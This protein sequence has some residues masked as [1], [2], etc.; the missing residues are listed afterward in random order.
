MSNRAIKDPYEQMDAI[1]MYQDGDAN[2]T[3]TGQQFGVSRQSIRRLCHFFDN[4]PTLYKNLSYAA[5]CLISPN[6]SRHLI[7][8]GEL[9]SVFIESKMNTLIATGIASRS[10]ESDAYRNL[11][12][13]LMNFIGEKSFPTAEAVVEQAENWWA[14][15]SERFYD[16]TGQDDPDEYFGELDS[17]DD[18]DDMDYV[19]EIDDVKYSAIYTQSSISV[20]KVE[21][22]NSV[23]PETRTISS[24]N[25]Q[26]RKA[27]RLIKNADD[28]FAQDVCEDIWELAD[29]RSTLE[30]VVSGNLEIDF[31]TGKVQYRGWDISQN[32]QNRIISIVFDE[33]T[34][35]VNDKLTRFFDKVLENPSH[36]SVESLYDFLQ[37]NDIEID[38]DGYVIAYKNVRS[39]MRDCFTGSID[40]SVGQKPQ[41]PRH[42]IDEDIDVHCSKGLHV[43]A[44]G[45]TSVYPGQ[46]TIKVKVHP[47]D[48][49][50]VPSDHSRQKARVAEYEV[51]SIV[52]DAEKA[53]LFQ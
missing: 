16:Q 20:T 13:Y 31:S 35:S 49:V 17:G 6:S 36:T 24:G 41:M 1:V 47:K 26:F 27:W 45:Y 39:D 43:C 48:F 14:T 19:D 34:A 30:K 38:D 40:N 42:L 23:Y 53:Q 51:L 50:A 15:Y 10:D 46:V 18:L 12:Y 52:D 8:D 28:P 22:G 11:L 32:M 9:A 33:N 2:L 37:H 25:P 4:L 3:Q 44:I 29:I 21:Q 7:L 5:Q